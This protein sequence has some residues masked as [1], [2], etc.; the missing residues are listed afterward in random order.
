MPELSA[1]E[2]C[3]ITDINNISHIT[4]FTGS[5]AHLLKIKNTLHLILDS[6]YY[7]NWKDRLPACSVVQLKGDLFKTLGKLIRKYT[8]H[9]L[10]IEPYHM[11]VSLHRQLQKNFHVELKYIEKNNV[12]AKKTKEEIENIEKALLITEEAF[13]Y[14]L[15]FIREGIRERDIEIELD[16]YM[17]MKGSEGAS[18]PSI[19]ASGENSAYPHYST[20][21]RKIKNG[22][23]ILMDFGARY[24]SMCSDITRTVL[25]GKKNLA[26]KKTIYNHVNEVREKVISTVIDSMTGKEID[27]MSIKYFKKHK[28]DRYF[29]HGTGHGVG[30]AVHEYPSLSSISDDTISNGMVFTV[31][32][33]LYFKGKFGIRIEDMVVIERGKARRLNCSTTD[34]LVM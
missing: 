1:F 7:S 32:P 15:A 13:I 4:G 26:R 29:L 8:V 22:D 17:R 20:G 3:Y 23:V 27:A 2:N 11:T 30:Y 34:L 25:F 33:G 5:T 6:R 28:L 24:N 14:I 19:I 21:S 9:E 16:H 12:R 18:F 31:E 10:Y